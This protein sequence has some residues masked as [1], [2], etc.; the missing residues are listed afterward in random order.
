MP[1]KL[2][3]PTTKLKGP[4]SKLGSPHISVIIWYTITSCIF[5][6]G[7]FTIMKVKREPKLSLQR[8]QPLPPLYFENRHIHLLWKKDHAITKGVHAES[9][10][11]LSA[12]VALGTNQTSS[13]KIL[14]LKFY[15]SFKNVYFKLNLNQLELLSA[16]KTSRTSPAPLL[17]SPF[18]QVP[19]VSEVWKDR[20]RLWIV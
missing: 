2:P 6:P 17:F 15:S 10:R 4:W 13:F 18:L 20:L 8:R 14:I 11:K 9:E 3:W 1:A 19:V 7:D 16:I 12:A 5:S